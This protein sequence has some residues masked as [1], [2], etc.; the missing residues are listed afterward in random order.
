M[1]GSEGME[2]K[3]LLEN[4]IRNLL[5]KLSYEKELTKTEIETIIKTQTGFKRN[6]RF[7]AL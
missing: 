6:T 1:Q 2:S 4:N 5:A 7:S 3:A